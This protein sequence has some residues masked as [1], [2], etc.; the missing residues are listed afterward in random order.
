MKD[1]P[2]TWGYYIC[3]DCCAGYNYLVELAVVYKMMKAIDPCVH[4]YR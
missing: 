1:H 3:D 2:A 4:Q